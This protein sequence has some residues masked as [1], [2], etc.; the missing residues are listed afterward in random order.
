MSLFGVF[1]GHNGYRGSLYVREMLLHNI[2]S[3]L[4]EETSL[5]EVQSAIQQ[6]YVKTD[7]DFI[8]LGVRDGCCV[9]TVAVSPSFIIAANAGD[10][11][12]VLAVK[13]EEEGEEMGGEVR[14]IDLTE[15]HKPGRPD[16]QARIEAAGG[17]V[18]E[19]GVPRVMGYLAVSRAIGDA[20][21]KQFVIA[22]PEIHVKPREP[23]AQR[24]V[25][26]ATDGLWDVM[27]SQEAVEFVWK[28]WEEKDHGAEELVR[29]AY[30]LG[31][32]D[33]ICVMV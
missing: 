1:D 20:E 22:E 10:S 19:L 30:R 23:Q 16:E 6:A 4:E 8:S 31:S 12:A 29:E 13:A 14:A 7:Q 3:S 32:Y 33:N 28:K 18:V 17:F 15:D 5:A 11:R 26:L 25:L 2:A 21:L 9:V 27:S 24:F